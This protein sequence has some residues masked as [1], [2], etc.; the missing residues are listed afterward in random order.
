[1]ARTTSATGTTATA[2]TTSG[3]RAPRLPPTDRRTQILAAARRVLEVRSIDEISVET[4]ATEAGVSPGLLFHYFGS[5]RTFRHA[6]LQSATDELL[7][8]IR[9]DPAL[10]PAEQLRAGLDTFVEYVSRH[11]AIY[12]AV[13]RLNSGTGIRT[14]H[15]SART[16]L[17]GW[18]G[19]ALAGAGMPA[20]PALALV[21]SGW[22]A[23]VEEVVLAWLDRPE[24]ER[25]ELIGLCERGFY[26]LVMVALDDPRA[27]EQILSRAR[28][29]PGR[30]G[31]GD[32]GVDGEDAV[33]ADQREDPDDVV[34]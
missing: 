8:H 21:V 31:V 20:G 23:Y 6:V 13:T 2:T 30:H 22:L 33:Q 24:I 11:P 28:A 9:P 4:V 7:A 32:G 10:S 25:T 18:L 34:G 12:R 15:R 26:Q 5:Q 16:T 14:L 1:M 29:R 17:A 27:W 19:E 3:A